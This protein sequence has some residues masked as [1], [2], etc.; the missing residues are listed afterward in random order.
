MTK[1]KKTAIILGA[2][3]VLVLIIGGILI[4]ENKRNKAL[5]V[6]KIPNIK[7]E[8]LHD[9]QSPPVVVADATLFF[10][11]DSIS[12]AVGKDFDL[13]A[14]VNPGSNADKG[15]NAVQLDMTFDPAILQLSG[16]KEIAPFAQMGTAKIDNEKGTLSMVLFIG[17]S[18]ATST[19]DLATLSFQAKNPSESSAI[20]FASTAE[21][22]INDGNGSMV[23]GTKKGATVVISN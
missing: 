9:Y 18:G 6:E 15:V 5:N 13:I 11:Q 12:V 16:V 3:L 17:A 8:E 1:Y 19:S 20:S 22:A 21:V 23:L 14:Q 4:S 2:I 7:Q 10:N